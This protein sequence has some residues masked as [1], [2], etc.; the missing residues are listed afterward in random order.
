MYMQG[1]VLLPAYTDNMDEVTKELLIFLGG[2]MRGSYVIMALFCLI[3][4]GKS[5]DC[6]YRN[7]D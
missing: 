4:V 5:K 2:A 6:E 3:A 7:G 1:D